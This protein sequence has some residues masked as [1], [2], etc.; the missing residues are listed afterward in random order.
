M[1]DLTPQSTPP[2]AAPPVLD[3]A[4]FEDFEGFRETTLAVFTDPKS[5]AALRIVGELLYSLALE[6]WQHWPKE[7]EGAFF[8]QSRAVL[9]DL[10]H[11]QGWLA[12]LGAERTAS[13]LT[14]DEERVSSLFESLAP[15]L[16]A[17]ADALEVE[18]GAW[19]GEE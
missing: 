4:L 8:H 13:A 18:L 19:R 14:D 12:H 17:I 2:A 10:R 11:L 15:D 16:K 3:P 9:A 7:S 1:P 6:F 5:N